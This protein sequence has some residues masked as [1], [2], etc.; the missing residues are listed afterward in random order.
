[1]MLYSSCLKYFEENSI[2]VEVFFKEERTKDFKTF[3]EHRVSI[4]LTITNI[5]F[6]RRLNYTISKHGVE[7]IEDKKNSKEARFLDEFQFYFFHNAKQIEPFCA[8]YQLYR[9]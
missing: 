9:N 7:R 4:Y 1:M 6:C 3:K 8:F 2:L 5:F